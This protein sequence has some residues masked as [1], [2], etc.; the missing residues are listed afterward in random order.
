MKLPDTTRELRAALNFKKKYTGEEHRLEVE[1]LLQLHSHTIRFIA[2]RL[3]DTCVPYALCLTDELT[4]RALAHR[5]VYA[6]KPFMTWLITDRLQQLPE[7]QVGCLACYFSAEGW[8]HVGVATAA[9][10]A[11]SKWGQW[12][13]YEHDLSE[14]TDEFGD[15]VNFFA[16]PSNME[17]IS[18]FIEFAKR[19]GLSDHDIAD[20]I[21]SHQRSTRW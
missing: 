19:E 15:C 7:A 3:D 14:V 11:R 21:S 13:A 2:S 8:T 17:A 12:P 16:R 1:K 20:A 9:H 6:G 4:Y 10:R 5:D 18:L